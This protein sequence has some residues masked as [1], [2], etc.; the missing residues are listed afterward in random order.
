MKITKGELSQIIKEEAQ[1]FIA[2]QKLKAEKVEIEK[3]LNESYVE[4][5][6][7]EGALDFLKGKF[8]KAESEFKNKYKSEIDGMMKAYKS[9]DAKYVDFVENLKEK[10]NSEYQEL[11]KKYEISG[12]NDMGVFQ[13]SLM[14]LVEPMDIPTFKR[15]MEKGT[16]IEDIVT[17]AS[18]G[19]KGWTTNKNESTESLSE[20]DIRKIA[21][22]EAVKTG[23]LK[24]LQERA[25]MISKKLNN[26]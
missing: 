7:G 13:K 16:S 15:Q 3:M 24:Q 1:R 25:E 6:L 11:A 20:S 2:I 4:E 17:G 26:L 23:K 8:G 22:E 12:V 18:A 14:K 21:R 5:D 10:V 19:R 9:K